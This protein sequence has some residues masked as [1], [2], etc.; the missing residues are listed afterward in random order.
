MTPNW[1]CL[2]YRPA[3]FDGTKVLCDKVNSTRNKCGWSFQKTS[4][5]YSAVSSCL[6]PGALE[7]V[8]KAT[9]EYKFRA[10]HYVVRGWSALFSLSVILENPISSNLGVLGCRFKNRLLLGIGIWEVSDLLYSGIQ[11]P[12]CICNAAWGRHCVALPITDTRDWYSSLKR[13]RHS[14]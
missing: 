7:S 4:C 2:A 14:L 10:Q 9:A 3:A 6:G 13:W 11:V 1:T 12:V 8:W 5:I